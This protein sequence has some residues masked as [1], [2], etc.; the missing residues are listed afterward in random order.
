MKYLLS[1]VCCLILSN[2]QSQDVVYKDEFTSSVL[3]VGN[4]PNG[5][6]TSLTDGNFRITGNGGAGQ[7]AAMTYLFHDGSND[8]ILIDASESPKIYI[9]AK[10]QNQ[11]SL[12][13]DFQDETG[14][15]TNQNPVEITLDNSSNIYE[16]DY[17]GRMIDGAYGGPCTSAPCQV[18]ASKLQALILFVNA[19]T[20]GYAG[21]IDIEWI[22]IGAPL[23]DVDVSEIHEIRYNQVAY[24][25]GRDKVVS[26]VANGPF[27][28]LG[29]SIYRTGD[30]TPILESSTSSDGSWQP[31]GE[32]VAT[33]DMSTIDEPGEYTLETSSES[34]N[35]SVENDGYADLC[36]ASL[37]YYYYNR[38]SQALT[39]EYAGQWARPLGHP[40]DV[41]II[42]PSAASPDRPSGSTISSPKGWYDA[43]DYNKYIVNS[44][45]STYTLLAAYEHYPAYY[46]DLSI[47]I[48]ENGGDIPDILDEV[49]WNLDWMLTMQDPSDGGVY[50]KLTGL[51]FSGIVMPHQYNFDRYVVQKTTAAALNFAAVMATASRIFEQ[52]DSARPGYSAAM[53]EAAENAYQWAK[54][55]PT[56]YYNQPSNVR[57]GE[58]GDSNVNDEFD[59][60][61]AE[62][63][64]TT[65]K[66]SYKN[67]INENSIGN[68]VPAWPYTA[69]LAL[70]SLA[71]HGSAIADDINVN[72]VENRLISTAN[73]LRGAVLQSSMRVA[74][75]SSNGDFVWG[76]NGQA[77]NQIM[78]LIRAY[79][80]TQ[81]QSYLDA[82]YTAMDYLLGR[83]G[84]GFCY[85]SGFGDK[86]PRKPHHRQSEAD[87]VADP[88]PGMV[89]GGPNPG[90]Q[91]GCPGYIGGSP[92]KAYVDS[93]C[94][95]ASN[96][97]TIN[98]N[99]PLAYA[100]NA[101]RYYQLQVISSTKDNPDIRKKELDI[102]PNPGSGL[103]Y[104]SQVELGK[105]QDLEVLDSSGKMVYTVTNISSQEVDLSM[106]ANGLYIVRLVSKN[107]SRLA[108]WM[109]VD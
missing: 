63:F 101:L 55:N 104:L 62:L 14:Y 64:I 30:T 98:W 57:T 59:W 22:S 103:V 88:V 105:N 5:Y 40:D 90:M 84:T 43:G 19:P 33:I 96:E 15:V 80:S 46:D 48:P 95:Y 34:I 7:W 45:I 106:L 51:N 28:D 31:S 74:M 32:H 107:E 91:D 67:D 49:M 93:W 58:Y 65:S 82:A 81:D 25:S 12:R 1:L 47:D 52:Y 53:I 6:T 29:Y 18:D 76:S 75:G 4:P 70:I 41:V 92:A 37:K 35:F 11:P 108:K 102:Y 83:N 44:G 60:A 97:V 26:I 42:H 85:V 9:K 61:A 8:Q 36:E 69:P 79:E 39:T 27:E 87:N 71:H 94:S 54:D 77:G 109:K 66:D 100:I 21:D 3:S 17:T 38:A 99:A 10:G 68:G 72:V 13:I 56:T 86:S 23:E 16:Y 50:H 24:L 89:A 2:V 20:G 78:I 73:Q